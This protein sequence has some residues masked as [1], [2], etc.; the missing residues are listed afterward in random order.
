MEIV[1][2]L[3]ADWCCLV[4]QEVDRLTSHGFRFETEDEW[5]SRQVRTLKRQREEILRESGDTRNV[6]LLL[7]EERLR[8]A[9]RMDLILVYVD[10]RYRLIEPRPRTL[11]HSSRFDC[12]EHLRDGLS[13]LEARI[14]SGESLFPH[15]S[16]QIFNATKQDG[17][18]F[19]W[20][21]HHLHLGLVPSAK[22]PRVI[23]GTKEVVYASIADDVAYFLVIG[24]HI[25]WADM[26]LIRIMKADFPHLIEPFALKGIHP[27]N[28]VSEADRLRLRAAGAM[29]P[30]E[31]DGILYLP[32]G[33]GI[34][35]A[36]GSATSITKLQRTIHWY[37]MAESSMK[38]GLQ[39][40]AQGLGLSEDKLPE[41]ITLRMSKLEDDR[42]TV[43][44][45][46]QKVRLVLRYTTERNAFHYLNVEGLERVEVS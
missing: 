12:P 28:P 32:P 11:R 25:R 44:G 26:D 15:L 7:S 33:G 20:G 34:N 35:T 46:E 36:G 10:F 1:M 19:D 43:E 18:L 9:Y 40:V 31:I 38:K 22:D 37:N 30:V 21:I 5:R 23:E 3:Y 4:L 29:V 2:N 6:D 42:I 27:G 14:R 45:E 16:R 17:M 24:N 39:S 13:A 8:S 41:S